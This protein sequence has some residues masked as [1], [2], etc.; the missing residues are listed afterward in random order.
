MNT[1]TNKSQLSLI[2]GTL[3]ISYPYSSLSNINKMD[4]YN[5]IVQTYLQNKNVKT[6]YTP[7]IDTAYYYGN[8]ECE[9]ILGNILKNN[10]NNKINENSYLISTKANP[11]FEN[12]FTNNI[13]GGLSAYNLER[14]LTE[15]L[16]NLQKDKVN[17]FYLHCPDHSTPIIETF[18]KANELWRKEKFNKLGLSNFSLSELKIIMNV[19]EEEDLIMPKYYQGMYNILCRKV[20]E[21][22]PVLDEYNIEFWAYNPLAGGLLSGKYHTSAS[23]T[24]NESNTDIITIKSRFK[25]NQ[26]YKN[27]FWKDAL[28][29]ATQKLINQQE[30]VSTVKKSF[31]WLQYYSKLR[32][33]DKIILGVSTVKQLDENLHC[34]QSEC[35]LTTDSSIYMDN[36][37][38]NCKESTPDYFY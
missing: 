23:N 30:D 8:T 16:K 26:I 17:I 29:N 10:K 18:E 7:I 31:D 22:F 25:D 27:I 34:L 38:I 19:C 13:L 21:I 36:I 1:N 9:K 5:S 12:D 35:A 4:E 3:N 15:S 14:Q 6:N 20:E 24:N 32:E 11:W 33:N 28:L 37:Y 2:L